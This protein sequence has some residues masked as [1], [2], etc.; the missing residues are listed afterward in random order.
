MNVALTEDQ[1]AIRSAIEQIGARFANPRWRHLGVD[2][3]V[4]AADEYFKD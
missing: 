3:A 2:A 4:Q 1:R